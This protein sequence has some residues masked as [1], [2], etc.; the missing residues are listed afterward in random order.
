M[1]FKNRFIGY[2]QCKLC[3]DDNHIMAMKVMMMALI[4]MMRMKI[5]MLT[6]RPL[7]IL[8]LFT[9]PHPLVLYSLLGS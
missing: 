4:I 5:M 1:L 8:L 2:L 6:G 3:D 7:M 9:I